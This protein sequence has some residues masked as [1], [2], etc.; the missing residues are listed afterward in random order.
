MS[1]L[2]G[3]AL[4]P[5]ILQVIALIDL[6]GRVFG[7]EAD[8]GMPDAGAA[9]V[10]LVSAAGSLRRVKPDY[11]RQPRDQEEETKQEGS[12]ERSAC[13]SVTSPGCGHLSGWPS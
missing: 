7:P 6:P 4:K 12:G 3:G 2:V 9:S 13:G 1:C 8:A 11:E 10:R 5:P